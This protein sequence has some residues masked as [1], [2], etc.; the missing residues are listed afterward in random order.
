MFH[1]KKESN[2]DDFKT[3]DFLVPYPFKV[4]KNNTFDSNM[5]STTMATIDEIF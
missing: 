5:I 4:V 2:S 1:K 3:F